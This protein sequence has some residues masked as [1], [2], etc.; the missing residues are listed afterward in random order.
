[1]NLLPLWRQL[2]NILSAARIGASP[3]LGYLAASGAEQYF[4]WLLVPALLSDVADGYLARRFRLASE[5]G[6]RLDSI[7]DA[8][9]FFVAI[10]AVWALR[11]DVL[12]AHA[13]AGLLVA[14][15]WLLEIAAALVRYGRLSSFHTYASKVA[16][17]LLGILIGALFVWGLWP[18]LLYAAVAVS[19]AA[20][21]EE[22]LL[23]ALLPEWRA[24]V[25]GAWWVLRERRALPG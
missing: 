23:I 8:L 2:P 4:T 16:G 22:L 7:A 1:M 9:L 3:L 18:P 20:S 6:A 11:P 15:G 21:V 17:Y 5:L 19:L 13:L 10:F 24:N 12:Q 25:R 14:G